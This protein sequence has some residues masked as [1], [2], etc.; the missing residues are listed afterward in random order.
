VWS[1]TCYSL[2]RLTSATNPE[3]GTISYSYDSNGNLTQK[4]DAR[5][6]VTSFAYDALNRLIAR[7]YTNDG[8]LTPPVNYYYDNASLPSGAPASFNRGY[9]TGRLV[10][11]TY[12][13]SSSNGDYRGY[14]DLLSFL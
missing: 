5:S 2:K 3:S 1:A 4:T 14:D 7:S 10:A 9:A 13:S 8:G 12:G 11:V 6:I